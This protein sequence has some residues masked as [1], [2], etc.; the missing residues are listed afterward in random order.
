MTEVAHGRLYLA[1][2][3]RRTI[4]HDG[5]RGVAGSRRLEQQLS[6]HISDYRHE[7][8][9]MPWKLGMTLVWEPTEVSL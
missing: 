9:R 8:E 6:A 5:E 2:G 7:A 4:V 3:A 1:W